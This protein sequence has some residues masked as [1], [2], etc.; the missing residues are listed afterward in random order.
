M[1]GLGTLATKNSVT[2][3]QVTGLGSLA[4]KSTIT[5]A[6]VTDLGDLATKD[7]V[8]DADITTISAGKIKTGTFISNANVGIRINNGGS[9]SFYPDNVTLRGK[10]QT[11]T[12]KSIWVEG[13]QS[14]YLGALR[15]GINIECLASYNTITLKSTYL[16]FDGAVHAKDIDCTSSINASALK[17]GGVFLDLAKA[18][19]D[20]LGMKYYSRGTSDCGSTAHYIGFNWANSGL[21]VKVDNA[22]LIATG[23]NS[24]DERLKT[25]IIPITDGLEKITQ[26]IPM[27][28]R[29]KDQTSKTVGAIAQEVI[30]I[31]PEA[32]QPWPDGYFAIKYEIFIPYLISAVKEL[33]KKVKA[34]EAQIGNA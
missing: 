6:S 34:L 5:S 15:G 28:F 16:E 4:T 13:Y 27:S 21:K 17:C 33:D 24:S 30:D 19:R 7:K 31:I 23:I 3:S 32:V 12:E 2:T 11:T 29:F 9:I 20:A 8:S 25:D 22:A 10:I 18:Q 26:I 1:T 14:V